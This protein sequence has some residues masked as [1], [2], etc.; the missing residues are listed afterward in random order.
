MSETLEIILG[1]EKKGLLRKSFTV[2]FP[3]CPKKD[4]PDFSH[5]ASYISNFLINSIGTRQEYQLKET[6]EF[7]SY[8]AG[9]GSVTPEELA[10]FR[11]L[12]NTLTLYLRLI[13]ETAKKDQVD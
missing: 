1:L 6:D 5:A 12:R 2:Q 9:R 8:F 10:T 13:D 3:N 4:H 11:L 7:A